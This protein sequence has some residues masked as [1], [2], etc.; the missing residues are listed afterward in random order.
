MKLYFK[1]FDCY[2]NKKP[3]EVNDGFYQPERFFDL[4]RLPTESLMNEFAAFIIDR[5]NKLTYKSLYVDLKSYNLA[6]EF[7]ASTYPSLSSLLDLDLDTVLSEQEDFLIAREIKPIVKSN[8]TKG[9][10]YHPSI[11]YIQKAFF[12]IRPKDFIYFKELE[13]YKNA[14]VKSKTHYT[15]ES[16]FDLDEAP[17][18]LK[19][20]FARYIKARGAEL[21]YG[22]IAP[23]KTNYTILCKFI[24]KV[25]PRMDTFEGVNRDHFIRKLKVYLLKNGYSLSSESTNQTTGK[26]K[27]GESSIVKYANRILD[28]FLPDDGLFHFEDDVWYVD[29]MD[30]E[31]R[32]SKTHPIFSVNFNGICTSKMK[33]ELKQ[34]SMIR[35]AQVSVSSVSTDISA[36]RHFSEFIC[37]AY[38]KINSFT[39]VD[40]DVLE[41]YFIHLNTADDRRESYSSELKH[42]K[43][44]L[45][46]IGKITETKAL[47]RLFLPEDFTRKIRKI[48]R[49]YTDSEIKRWN[50]A[51]K[52]LEPQTGRIMVIHELLGCR[53][54]E[55]LTLKSDCITK[56]DGIYF[57]HIDQ[58]KVNRSFEKP[59]SEEIKALVDAS[60]AYTTEKY[61]PCEYIFVNHN[62]PNNPMS[63]AALRSRLEKMIY[64]NDLRDDNGNLFSPKTHIFRHVFGSKLCDLGLDDYQIAALLGHSGTASVAFYRKMSDKTL[65]D[66]TA[67]IRSEKDNLINKYKGGWTNG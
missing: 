61:G 9:Y 25:F 15:P 48:P 67:S 50:E 47:T 43:S 53:I 22:S 39:E 64:E 18:K 24:K 11:Y 2:K 44:V 32:N 65:A 41:A 58:N 38:P 45:T 13:C 60:I 21:D 26:T 29:R 30:I 7:F 14:D 54:S 66:N 8:N 10:V 16:Y 42:L 51:L 49:V 5:G 12:F 62:N 3:P 57:I 55:T 59:I 4:A 63:Y 6:S 56:K 1:E 33:D 17:K 35:L 36:T 19:D 34:A 37:Y 46:I 28:F 31:I 52:T 20:E 40:R 27:V 23:E